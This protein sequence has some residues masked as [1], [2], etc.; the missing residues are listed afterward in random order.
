MIPKPKAHKAP[1]QL[2]FEV[3]RRAE[4]MGEPVS[5]STVYSVIY[6][7][8]TSARIQTLI[9][10]VRRDLKISVPGKQVA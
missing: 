9:D 7:R 2:I 6:G 4:E 3:T 1:A 10:E 5:A 8:V